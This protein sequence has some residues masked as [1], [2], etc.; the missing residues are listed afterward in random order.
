[1]KKTAHRI[2][3]LLILIV[4]FMGS[5]SL[6]R[7]EENGTTFYDIGGHWAQAAIER[8]AGYGVINTAD[9]F[10]RPDEEIRI[11]EFAAIIANLMNYTNTAGFDTVRHSDLHPNSW[12]FDVMLKVYA[13]GVLTPS[14][15]RMNPLHPLTRELGAA[16]L[17]RAFQLTPRT[18]NTG[19]GD[20]YEINL[21]LRPLIRAMREAGYISGEE[22]MGS[23][24][25]RPSAF[26]TRAEAVAMLDGMVAVYI[27][28]PGV[29][30]INGARGRT[31]VASPG[32]TIF[33]TEFASHSTIFASED[34]NGLVF[35]DIYLS[36]GDIHLLT[37]GRVSAVNSRIHNVILDAP[38]TRIIFET[39]GA[40]AVNSVDVRQ[41]GVIL[42]NQNEFHV[43]RQITIHPD[44][45]RS[46]EGGQ[47]LT[48]RGNVGSLITDGYVRLDAPGVR[49]NFVPTELYGQ[50]RIFGHRPYGSRLTVEV[51]STVRGTAYVA[52]TDGGFFP[53]D[54]EI[55][56]VLS[57]NGVLAADSFRVFPGNVHIFDFTSFLW[58]PITFE[59]Q[60]NVAHV[61][62][63]DEQG[64]IHRIVSEP[65]YFMPGVTH[66]RIESPTTAVV[67]FDTPF[68]NGFAVED[69]FELGI[70]STDS[71]YETPVY[72]RALNILDGTDLELQSTTFRIAL[73]FGEE[74]SEG[75]ILVLR[76]RIGSKLGFDIANLDVT[77]EN[78]FLA[79][80]RPVISVDYSLD[81]EGQTIA[82]FEIFYILTDMFIEDYFNRADDIMRGQF[83]N[84]A[85][86]QWPGRFI[87]NTE[88][89]YF[90]QGSAFL[91]S[92]FYF[93]YIVTTPLGGNLPSQVK[94]F[95]MERPE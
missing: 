73:L 37:N 13:A 21:H 69:A 29:Y 87:I 18:G 59:N 42:A 85:G 57:N 24:M 77:S 40:T 64:G 66:L 28:A 22:V 20:N 19:F 89:E 7:A 45:D 70:I 90:L 4:F 75:D 84:I 78:A 72:F 1:M 51:E 36:M 15:N 30:T 83:Q 10:F 82:P 41:G 16:M 23:V 11:A 44:F 81:I 5:T 80:F 65:I 46:E 79:S 3:C 92:Q 34:T 6:A 94:L 91:D 58:L 76:P 54:D 74:L 63:E 53:L 62:I 12:Y 68:P 35:D 86:R 8:W 14:N 17:A 26:L 88:G 55:R 71:N 31:L 95:V 25:F 39:S 67:N 43:I 38:S 27:N 50:N 33:Q 48:L 61:I 2:L 9:G 47:S 56:Q 49:F 52:I 60:G 93:L 32:V